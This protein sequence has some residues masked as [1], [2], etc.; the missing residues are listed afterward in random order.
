MSDIHNLTRFID[1]QNPIYDSVLQELR[2]G[3]KRG[4]WMWYIFPQISGL[5]MSPI[6]Q[7]Y[8]IKSLDESKKYYAHPILGP[9]LQECTQLVMDVE[10]RTA[11]EIFGPIDSLKFRSCMTLFEYG[12]NE[13][14]FYNALV[15]YFGGEADQRTLDILTSCVG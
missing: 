14:L 5:G 4:H 6:S 3:V 12:T 10:G 9:R 1:A 15:K 13:Q 11:N 8:A 7:R 2:N